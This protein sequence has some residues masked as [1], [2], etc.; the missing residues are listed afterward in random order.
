MSESQNSSKRE[1]KS[2]TS[3]FKFPERQ[4]SFSSHKSLQELDITVSHG[5]LS[6]NRGTCLAPLSRRSQR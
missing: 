4:D 2:R 3:S 1:I 5:S 6:L